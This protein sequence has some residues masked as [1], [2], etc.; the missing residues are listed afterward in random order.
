MRCIP[1]GR[2]VLIIATVIAV[3]G[4]GVHLARPHPRPTPGALKTAPPRPPSPLDRRAAMVRIDPL[5]L[6]E[7]VERLEKLYGTRVEIDWEGIEQVLPLR[8]ES[9]V[10]V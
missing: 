1:P 2:V 6:G 4:V 8:P 9:Y 7:I 3:V 5:P 10:L